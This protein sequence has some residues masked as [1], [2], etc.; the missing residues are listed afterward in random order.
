[1]PA[2]NISFKTYVYLAPVLI[3]LTQPIYLKW[4]ATLPCATLENLTITHV[5]RE[6]SSLTD[7]DQYGSSIDSH[8]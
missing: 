5:S 4:H 7:P 2:T 8:S 6:I 3:N 1:M